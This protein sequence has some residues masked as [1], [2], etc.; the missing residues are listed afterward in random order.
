MSFPIEV[1]SSVFKYLRDIDLIE[2]TAV[3]TESYYIAKTARFAAK[4]KETNQ[5]FLD[6]DWLLKTYMKHFNRFR[7][8]VFWNILTNLQ[9]EKALILEREIFD[10][11]FYSILPFRIWSHCWCCIR[12]QLDPV[13]FVQSFEFEIKNC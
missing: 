7:D 5:L 4:L 1:F 8:E 2:A 12:S 13:S 3:C 6:K 10:R 9:N 11:M